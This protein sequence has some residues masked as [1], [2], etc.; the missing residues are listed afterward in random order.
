MVCPYCS[1]PEL[2]VSDSR[3][4]RG[5]TAIRR[6]REC[7]ACGRRFTTFEE[8]ERAIPTIVK[9]SGERA[10]YDRSKLVRSLT[11]A[12][13]K[14][15]VPTVVI[16]DAVEKLERDLMDLT[17]TEI[18]AKQLGE[19]AMNELYK[20]DRVAF[21]RFASVYYEFDEPAQFVEL[22]NSMITKAI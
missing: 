11:L 4:A 10:E 21:V 22:V 14:R 9:R 2:K 3:P 15:D 16:R 20:I 7:E 12:C 17:E 18:S 1:H 13:R 6:R 19:R 8:I 5:G